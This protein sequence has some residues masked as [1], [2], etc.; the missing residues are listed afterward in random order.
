MGKERKRSVC[1][2]EDILYALVLARLA[3]LVTSPGEIAPGV[4]VAVIGIGVGRPR[5][6]SAGTKKI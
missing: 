4:H 6:A 3:L 2:E 5:R 1:S